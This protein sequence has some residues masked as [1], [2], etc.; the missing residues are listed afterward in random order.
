N[1]LEA[2]YYELSQLNIDLNEPNK[3]YLFGLSYAFLADDEAYREE[4]ED[5]FEVAFNGEHP[6]EEESQLFVSQIVFQYLF[7]QGRLLE[8]REYLL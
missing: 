5:M 4:L 8:A 3:A 2:S 1:E 6:L 7:G